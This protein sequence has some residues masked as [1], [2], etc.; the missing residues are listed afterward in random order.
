M[1][2]DMPP[3]PGS[4]E[5]LSSVEA[6]L[7]LD[8]LSAAWAGQADA[9]VVGTGGAGIVAALEMHER[10]LEV[11]ALDRFDGGGATGISG[12]VYYGGGT[13][14]QREA[15]F[16][17]TPEEMYRYLR[18]EIRGSV[19]DETLRRFCQEN[20]PSMRWLEG[21]GVRFGS[22]LYEEKTTYP[23]DDCYLYFSGN[24]LTGRFPTVAKPAPRGHR[25]VGEGFTGSV[26]WRSLKTA[27]DS[28]NIRYTPQ[29]PVRRLVVDRRG[30]VLGVEVLQMP[31]WL[32]AVHGAV[33]AWVNRS[34][35]RM[36]GGPILK[37]VSW[38]LEKMEMAFARRRILQARSGVVLATGG[39]VQNS[40]MNRLYAAY[41]GASLPMGALSCDGSGIRLG[42]SVGGLVRDIGN[43][44]LSRAIAPAPYLGGV[45]VNRQGKRFIAEDA[46]N[47]TIGREVALE[48]GGEAWVIVDAD[49]RRQAVRALQWPT[50]VVMFLWQMRNV[51]S[52][53]L[54]TRKSRTL[55]GLAARLGIDPAALKDT[56]AGYN[57]AVADGAD[58]LG[59]ATQYLRPL[60]EG[61]FF[62]I[63]IGSH[64][65]VNP[66]TGF[67]LGGLLV[68][69]ETGQVMGAEGPVAGLYAAGRA[70]YGIPSNFYVSGLSIADC[71]FS[72]RR[73]G[74][75]IAASAG[76][77]LPAES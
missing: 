18:E 73:A 56:V 25:T 8:G 57:Q 63:D 32:A 50:H 22:K 39:Y 23:P 45:I 3:K 58:P 64:C 68:S 30:A 41:Q 49:T 5:W 35:L 47:A 13:R 37:T 36:V 55:E 72:G 44:D 16:E 69:E 1:S 71:V 31:N 46:Y 76:S 67:S 70:A 17:D 21:L 65:R 29:S 59:K 12:G 62:A 2:I 6:P 24:E 26:L 11:I 74:R 4:A 28:T 48:Q 20:E 54:G 15:G 75:S 34:L 60:G 61:P 38:L 52:M 66:T 14:H 51:L 53:V 40:G 77:S 19:S 27:M 42:Q 7:V 43:F 33:A 10:G 9:I